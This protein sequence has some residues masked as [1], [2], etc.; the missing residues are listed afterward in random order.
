MQQ[1]QL[2][3]AKA[4]HEVSLLAPVSTAL[5]AVLLVA[6]NPLGGLFPGLR[7]LQLAIMGGA[8]LLSATTGSSVLRDRLLHAPRNWAKHPMRSA[9]EWAAWLAALHAAQ[10]LLLSDAAGSVSAAVLGC[11]ICYIGEELTHFAERLRI[12]RSTRA[13]SA[14]KTFFPGGEA[15]AP[16]SLPTVAMDDVRRHNTPDDCWLVID[17]AVL[18][19]TKWAPRHPGSALIIT[20]LGGRDA[21]DPY[22]AFHG[23]A[24]GAH[25]RTMA[26]GRLS[27]E[28]AAAASP[29]QMR[30]RALYE[31]LRAE[32]AFTHHL[33]STLRPMMLPLVL[34]AGSVA[35]VAFLHANGAGV[36]A[37]AGAIAAGA[38]CGLAWQQM[39][40][41]G[42]DLGH[43][44]VTGSFAR[45]TAI[46]LALVPFFG[47]GA[48]GGP[49]PAPAA[50]RG[51]GA[52]GSGG[53]RGSGREGY[54]G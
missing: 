25:L 5:F 31:E 34:M 49:W 35:S 50:R 16:A 39:S 45:D 1:A 3:E 46:A 53:R 30:F 41:F 17:G 40:L 43:G 48:R 11:M 12:A 24:M 14:D 38:L 8:L 51:P 42:H 2:H 21:T 23:T 9:V 28:Q 32:G 27:P 29:A 19:V 20:S 37:L 7:S 18:D 33:A 52:C 10:K 47:I 4:P 13:F 15:L 54:E 6:S 26:V 44:N 36:G 22:K